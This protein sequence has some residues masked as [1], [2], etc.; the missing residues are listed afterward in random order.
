MLS[1][2]LRLSVERVDHSNCIAAG[3][4]ES[5]AGW[6]KGLHLKV[7]EICP[8][9]CRPQGASKTDRSAAISCARIAADSV[10][11]GWDRFADSTKE[12]TAELI[13]YESQTKT[14]SCIIRW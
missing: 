9:L 11:A 10:L 8:R 7:S 12:T 1:R 14:D 5:S 3:S 13:V 6:D 2:N 4:R